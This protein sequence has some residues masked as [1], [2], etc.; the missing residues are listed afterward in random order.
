M[1]AHLIS[2]VIGVGMLAAFLGF[3]L[4]WVPSPP[5]IIIVVIV[6]ALLLYDLVMEVRAE[7]SRAKR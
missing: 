4:V 2:G 6:L 3:M 1:I 7:S 5:L